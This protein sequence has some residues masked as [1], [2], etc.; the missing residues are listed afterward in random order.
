MP[1]DV[2]ASAVLDLAHINT[3]HGSGSVSRVFQDSSVVYHVQNSRLFHWTEDLLPALRDAGLKFETV[4]QREWV[5]RLRNSEKDPK[6]NPTIKL[7]EF[8]ADKYDNDNPGRKGLVFLTDKTA[9]ESN[10]IRDGYDIVG[11]G[12]VKKFVDSWSSEW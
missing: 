3:L 11:S 2:V 9:E 8:F 10:A 7:L 4:P 6:K 1:V 5:Q 12:L